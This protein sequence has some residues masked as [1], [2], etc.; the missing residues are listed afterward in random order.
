MCAIVVGSERR[1]MVH[2]VYLEFWR[3]I[4]IQLVRREYIRLAIA[5]V[6]KHERHATEMEFLNRIPH[7][8]I[9][10]II[11]LC[12]VCIFEPLLLLKNCDYDGEINLSNAS[13]TYSENI[14]RRLFLHICSKE[15]SPIYDIRYFWH[16]ESDYLKPE[17]VGVQLTESEFRRVCLQC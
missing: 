11:L 9:L 5:I 12:S 10:V 17:V 15:S 7:K 14:G 4:G 6:P 3:R 13:C 8:R 16:D 1:L 2:K